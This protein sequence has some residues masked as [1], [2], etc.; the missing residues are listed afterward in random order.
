MS[1]SPRTSHSASLTLPSLHQTRVVAGRLSSRSSHA[2]SSPASSPCLNACHKLCQQGALSDEQCE[3]KGTGG[4]CKSRPSSESFTTV[5]V[6]HEPCEGAPPPAWD[7]GAEPGSEESD[8]SI[9]DVVTMPSGPRQ[10]LP[11]PDVTRHTQDGHQQQCPLPMNACTKLEEQFRETF[12]LNR[13]LALELDA[14]KQE[15]EV[16]TARLREHD[17]H[18]LQRSRGR[19]THMNDPP[20]WHG[21]GDAVAGGISGDDCSA[22]SGYHG[23]READ[24][25]SHGDA[26]DGSGDAAG[27]SSHGDRTCAE[28]SVRTFS[29]PPKCKKPMHRLDP[30]STAHLAK[31]TPDSPLLVPCPVIGCLCSNCMSGSCRRLPGNKISASRLR[32]KLNDRVTTKSELTGCVRYIGHVDGSGHKDMIYVGLELDTPV[33]QHNGCL[34]GKRYFQCAKKYGVFVPVNDVLYTIHE[35]KSVVACGGRRAAAITLPRRSKT[36]MQ[37][38]VETL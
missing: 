7:A 10:P 27:S 33:G 25:C 30:N 38:L 16:L 23:H 9:P 11:S 8:S 4:W 22:D 29:K 17:A 19:N 36:P 15:I 3:K 31:S 2:S 26:C 32:T 35:S 37:E 28:D 24:F 5:A 12:Q 18:D 14:A 20:G 6:V 13:K 21:D 34:N 1:T